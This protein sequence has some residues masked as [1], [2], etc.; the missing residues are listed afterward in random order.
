MTDTDVRRHSVLWQQG[1]WDGFNN[2]SGL[3]EQPL[4]Y[5]E[6]FSMGRSDLWF[7]NPDY[8][9]GDREDC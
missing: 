3:V 7:V 1:Y 4:E 9:R 6:G 2:H 5:Y 8:W